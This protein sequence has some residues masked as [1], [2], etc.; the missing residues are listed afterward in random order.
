METEVKEVEQ[1]MTWKDVLKGSADPV[2]LSMTMP[3]MVSQSTR[4]LVIKVPKGKHLSLEKVRPLMDPMSKPLASVSIGA[5]PEAMRTD[6]IAVTE[7]TSPG[8]HPELI[9]VG[10]ALESGMINLETTHGRMLYNS[11]ATVWI[12]VDEDSFPSL[13]EII[14]RNTKLVQ[15]EAEDDAFQ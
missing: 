7:V 11:F 9:I 15:L 10:A 8:V 12:V 3:G 5:L 13:P 2:F 4:H 14:A 1:R 6:I